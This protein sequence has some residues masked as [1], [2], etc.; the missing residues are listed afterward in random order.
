[1]LQNIAEKSCKTG[2]F[3]PSGGHY[4]P[5]AV[6]RP[7]QQKITTDSPTSLGMTV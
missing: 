4:S 7:F 3:W 6:G 1:M 5:Q 2:F